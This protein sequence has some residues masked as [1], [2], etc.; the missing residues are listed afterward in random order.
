MFNFHK[1]CS[2]MSQ[3]NSIISLHAW[4]ELSKKKTK[5]QIQKFFKGQVEDENFERKMF[6]DTRI[7]ACTHKNSTSM[8]LFLFS[9]FSRGLSSIFLLCLITLFYFLTL[10]RGVAIPVTPPLDPPMK[11]VDNNFTC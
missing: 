9:S 8:Q 6:V 5:A 7:N 11:H 4:L 2:H 3:C 10:E 1:H